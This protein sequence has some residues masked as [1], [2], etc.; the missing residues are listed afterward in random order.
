MRSCRIGGAVANSLPF[1]EKCQKF[2]DISHIRGTTP[3]G[4]PG[5][6]PEPTTSVP[7]SGWS[8][9][10]S[11]GRDE[12]LGERGPQTVFLVLE[13]HERVADAGQARNRLRPPLDVRL[14]ISLVAQTEVS[15]IRGDLDR[16][17]HFLAV[18][19]AKGEI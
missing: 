3:V 2:S 13:V 12:A 11:Q 18:G 14:L 7:R 10:R 16:C 19:D 1:A 4:R 15:V 9:G 5:E 8:G 17:A 6:C